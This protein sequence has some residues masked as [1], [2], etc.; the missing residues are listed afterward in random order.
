[1]RR[2]I[3]MSRYAAMAALIGGLP[4]DAAGQATTTVARRAAD[5]WN[6]SGTTRAN[7]TY[8]L[9]AGSTVDGS[10]AVVNGPVTVGG[11][12]RG[13]LVAINADVR[14][15]PGARV[16]RDLVV[17]G[18]TVTGTDSATLGGE[19]LQQAE[20]LR[21]HLAGD[22]L[23]LDREPEYDDSWWRRRRFRR[24]PTREWS[25][26]PG[27]AD[28]FLA[29][30]AYNRIEGW[31]LAVGPRIRRPTS[32]GAYNLEFFAIAR[33]APPMRWD[34]ESV[35]HDAKAE[36]LFGKPIGIAL[37]ARAF[38][39]VTPTDEWSFGDTEVG[40]ASAL[41][42]RDFRD[43]YVKHGGSVFARLVAGRTVDLTVSLSDEQWLNRESRDPW[44]AALS[45]NEWRPNPKMDAGNVHLLTTRL[46]INTRNRES[47]RVGAWYLTAE[48]EQGGGR[49][50]RFGAPILTFA[51]PSPE[52]LWYSR[53]F[54]DV[55]RYNRI[56]PS[57]S[58]DMRVVAGGWVAGDP[59]PTQRRLG[60]GG[61]GSLPGYG[62]RETLPSSD[63]LLCT[64]SIVQGG[65]PPQ[66]DR[67]ALAQV[68]LRSGFLFGGWRNDSDDDWWRP[69]FN[70]RSSFVLFADAGRGWM[71]DHGGNAHDP[72][73]VGA[74][75]L[76]PLESF[77]VDVGAGVDFGDF[78]MYWAKAMNNGNDNPVRFIVRLQRRF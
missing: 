70:H 25:R 60:V 32:W 40:I 17:I 3:G 4:L 29:S 49:I 19:I 57:M 12:I 8:D 55:R 15:R 13:S 41:L 30:R 37:G 5:V 39:L 62:F 58:L 46:L 66:C 1:M 36:V 10:V 2:L 23:E 47:S 34:N 56:A 22:V 51:P 33:T 76:P 38:D 71:V 43:Y 9:T 52:D 45:A 50:T 64:N 77:K 6:A 35:G 61:P 68:Q 75:A 59:L 54:V 7:G 42:Q 31:S 72:L 14:L 11:T 69:G 48:M 20:L 28:F 53:A 73:Y 26:D 63:V 24:A 21:Y 44:S 27:Y 16:E 67:M 74:H 78:G 18:G 65:T